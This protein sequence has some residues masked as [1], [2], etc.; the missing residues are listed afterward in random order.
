MGSARP[1]YKALA[2]LCGT[3]D[4]GT[5]VEGMRRGLKAL[6]RESWAYR[7][8]RADLAKAKLPAIVLQRDH[9]VVLEGIEGDEATV[10]DPRLG[11]AEP[12]RLPPLD[13]PDFAATLI[14]LAKPEGM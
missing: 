4:D 13:D 9:Y 11:R 14:L 1:D 2:R 5:T 3:T 12:W 10:W 8:S 6:G 7:L